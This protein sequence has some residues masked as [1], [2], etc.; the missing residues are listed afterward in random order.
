MDVS[1][2]NL[3]FLRGNNSTILTTRTQN[4]PI[5]DSFLGRIH[6][7]NIGS[8]KTSYNEGE[9]LMSKGESNTLSHTVFPNPSNGEFSF[10]FEQEFSGS[11]QLYDNLGRLLFETSVSKK[12]AI[13]IS[14]LSTGVLSY[15]LTSKEGVYVGRLVLY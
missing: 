12:N 6:N 9:N 1:S 8:Y 2:L 15:V 5:S 10:S 4:S 7:S 14:I 3:D 13:S 11:V